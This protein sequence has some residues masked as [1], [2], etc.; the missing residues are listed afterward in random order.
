MTDQNPNVNPEIAPEE[1]PFIPPRLLL[2][3]AGVFFVA[4]VFVFLTQGAGGNII[5]FG[6]LA[7]SVLALVLWAFMAP[8]QARNVWTG[9]TFRY[10]GASIVVTVLLL[11]A[12]AIVYLV[13]RNLN[14]R[15]DLTERDEFSLTEE[16]RTAMQS[17]AADP[18]VPNVRILAFYGANQA[19]NRDRD[20]LL[21]EEYRQAANNKI[22]YQFLDPEQNF[23]LAQQ[24]EISR[25]GAVAVVALDET[26]Q[27]DTES[28]ETINFLSQ[29]ELTNAILK[30]AAQGDFAAYFLV[31][32]D[33]ANQE[34]SAIKESLTTRYDWTVRDL[35]LVQLTAP[36]AEFRLGD[37][38]LDGEVVV[39]PGGSRPLAAN[40][41]QILQDYINNGGD[42]IIFAAPLLTETSESLASDPA[43]N[44]YLFANFGVRFNQDVV[45]DQTQSFQNP[46]IPYTT[47]LD[48]ENFITNNGI[49]ANAAVVFEAPSSI[50]VVDTLPA[51]VAVNRL[52]ET[53]AESYTKT[54]FAEIL[55]GEVTAIDRVDTDASGPFVVAAAALNSE[56]GAHLVLFGS[57]APGLDTYGALSGAANLDVGFNSL[58]W[59]TNFNEFFRTI[60]IPQRQRP[61]DQPIFVD[62]GTLTTL[63]TLTQW[64]LPIGILVIGGAVLWS[65]RERRRDQ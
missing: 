41:L 7:F 30:V 48:S 43:L 28:A 33:G 32:Q 55:T 61:Q 19:G 13:V 45:V 52:A 23:P 20:T 15:Y 8:E 11:L 39:I 12:M 36:D 27:P 24:Y 29:S 37:P 63:T 53:S 21:F 6:L 65:S 40:E 16:S 44:E 18:T 38:A 50:A 31:V 9:R 46:L 4:A 47:N 60:T 35:S 17:L 25:E 26:G 51:N 22:E 56:T 14:L 3:L 58:I 57:L 54:N 64:I 5:L 34:M 10:G 1:E 62:Q 2:I 49:S 59:A 42:V